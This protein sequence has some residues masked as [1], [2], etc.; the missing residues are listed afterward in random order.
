[1]EMESQGNNQ[2]SKEATHLRVLAGGLPPTFFPWAKDILRRGSYHSFSL[3]DHLG[4]QVMDFT[5]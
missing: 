3:G 1:M 4:S 2:F 5:W